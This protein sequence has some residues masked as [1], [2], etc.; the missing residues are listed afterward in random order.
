ML[1]RS[2]KNDEISSYLV[3]LWKS[4]ERLH[5][6][7][8]LNNQF[9]LTYPSRSCQNENEANLP[10][11]TVSLGG[12]TYNTQKEPSNVTM[13]AGFSPL[14]FWTGLVLNVACNT[15]KTTVVLQINGNVH[16]IFKF[17]IVPSLPALMKNWTLPCSRTWIISFVVIYTSVFVAEVFLLKNNLKAQQTQ[18][19]KMD[20]SKSTIFYETGVLII[21]PDNVTWRSCVGYKLH[22][23]I[24]H[25]SIIS[26]FWKR[27]WV[28]QST[29]SVDGFP[30]QW[31]VCLTT[32]QLVHI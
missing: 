28:R 7:L 25:P 24:I 12:W 5:A 3:N 21:R 16:Y 32:A 8:I 19:L 30:Y 26:I 31:L 27:D 11:C 1:W 9:S 20:S 6:R 18:K 10:T 13:A 2:Y 29:T 17:S 14:L 23:Q 22:H 15:F 4:H